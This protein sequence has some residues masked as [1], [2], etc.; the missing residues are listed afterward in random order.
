MRLPTVLAIGA[1]LVSLGVSG[2]TADEDTSPPPVVLGGDRG[3]VVTGGGAD[4]AS[5]GEA[6]QSRA[7]REYVDASR[8]A[9]ERI[10]DQ[11]AP[12]VYSDFS[13]D[14]AGSST[15]V[16]TYTFAEQVDREGFEAYM[17]DLNGVM[18]ESAN[19][20]LTEMRQYG[21]RNPKVR[22]VY[23]N[24]DGSVVGSLDFD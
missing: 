13:V 15:L 4:E 20:P 19:L 8:S 10:V 23:L 16:Y 12:G 9:S 1:V 6:S 21:I 24:P 14:A 11:M 7:L 3:P 22:Y 17:A 5:G 18:R 2:C